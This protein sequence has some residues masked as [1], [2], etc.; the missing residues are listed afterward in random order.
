MSYSI[1]K[2][3]KSIPFAHHCSA[4]LYSGS[5]EKDAIIQINDRPHKIVSIRKVQFAAGVVTI[6]GRAALVKGDDVS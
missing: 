5:I 6:R 3:P 1:G 2:T 4:H